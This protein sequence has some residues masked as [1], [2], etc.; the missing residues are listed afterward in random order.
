MAT[1]K[2]A[3]KGALKEMLAKR[4]GKTDKFSSLKKGLNK[5]KPEGEETKAHETSETPK[6]EKG[7]KD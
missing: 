3:R 2:E 6:F 7:E 5:T 1:R 4:F